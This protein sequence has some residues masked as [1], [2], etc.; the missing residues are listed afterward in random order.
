MAGLV[1][2]I[3]TGQSLVLDSATPMANVAVTTKAVTIT[4]AN[5]AGAA[6]DAAEHN[7]LVVD[8]GALKAEL[9]KT[10]TDLGAIATA[11]NALLV[12]LRSNGMIAPE[13]ED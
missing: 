3:V 1:Q 2:G 6:P 4:G 10:I 9:D 7:A 13:A 8:V 12:E 11:Y 5:A